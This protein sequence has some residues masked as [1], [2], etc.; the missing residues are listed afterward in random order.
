MK[1]AHRQKDKTSRE[2]II[3][4]MKLSALTFLE[5]VRRNAAIQALLS[6][7][8]LTALENEHIRR[9]VIKEAPIRLSVAIDLV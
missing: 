6:D 5:E 1:F 2:L 8:F 4:D 7:L 3:R 9:D